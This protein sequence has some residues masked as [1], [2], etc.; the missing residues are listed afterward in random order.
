RSWETWGLRALATIESYDTPAGRRYMVRYRTPNRT[1]TKKRGFRTKRAA[2]EFAATVEVSKMAGEYVQPSL[3]RV[4]VAELAPTWLSRKESDVAKSN[5]R[6]LEIAWRVH[7]QP[8]WGP[9]RLSDIDLAD[10]ESWIADL[11][12]K[13]GATTV[14]RAY[15]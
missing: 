4:T 8:R 3:G 10:V 2:Q 1:Q 7:V 12:R 15:G 5:Y 14:I 6:T 11:R 13:R 9:V